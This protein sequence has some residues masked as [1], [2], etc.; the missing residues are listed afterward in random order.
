MYSSDMGSVSATGIDAQCEYREAAT[1][2]KMN[3]SSP[4]MF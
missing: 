1:T 3:S 4:L 2:K